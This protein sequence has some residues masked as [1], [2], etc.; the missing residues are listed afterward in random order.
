MGFGYPIHGEIIVDGD[1]S[2]GVAVV[3][4]TSGTT[5]VRTL[6]AS[7]FLVITDIQIIVE[8]S[9]D[10][11]LVADSKAAGR[12]L[13]HGNVAANG[14]VVRSLLSPYRCPRGVGLK[15]YG[16]GQAESACIVEG[17]I[18]EA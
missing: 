10:I 2:G 13:V 17:Y 1:A 4:Y 5:D 12:Y 11:S 8:A 9:A 16:G 18:T 14:G 7:E 6:A 3:L 15:F